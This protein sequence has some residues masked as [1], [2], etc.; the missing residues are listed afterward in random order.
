[1]APVALSDGAK[2]VVCAT[3]QRTREAAKGIAS[4]AGDGPSRTKRYEHSIAQ[5]TRACKEI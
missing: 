5:L 3:W 1:M 4:C 2:Y